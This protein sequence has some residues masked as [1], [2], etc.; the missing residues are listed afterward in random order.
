MSVGTY[1]GKVNEDGSFYVLARV[2]SLDG[3]G[4]EVVPGEGAVLQ[5]ADVSAIT[6]KVYDLGTNRNATSG[7]EVTP[8]PTVTVSTSVF[9]ALR[10]VGW[11]KDTWGYNFRH[12]LSASYAPTGGDWYLLEYKF[13]LVSGG[14]AWLKVKV[15]AQSVL[16][17]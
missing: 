5:Q 6:C 4:E 1:Y 2:C 10:T 14:V 17:S 12:D 8:A 15:Q 7:T 11:D 13:T 16:T 9:D 3:S